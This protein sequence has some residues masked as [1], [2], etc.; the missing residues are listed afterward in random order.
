MN[1]SNTDLKQDCRYCISA[2]GR[3]TGKRIDI[4]GS[5]SPTNASKW[6]PT[7]LDKKA[8][9]YFKISRYPYYKQK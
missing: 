8:F 6:E 4:T 9:R 2:E 3:N 1:T 5:L 7:H